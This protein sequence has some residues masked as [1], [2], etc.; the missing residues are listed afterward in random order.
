MLDPSAS[1][2]VAFCRTLNTKIIKISKS[3]EFEAISAIAPYEALYPLVSPHVYY[4]TGGTATL[5]TD[6]GGA[7]N[8]VLKVFKLMQKALLHS[9]YALAGLS[10]CLVSLGACTGEAT[11]L[12]RRDSG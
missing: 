12:L 10:K 6:T 4:F 11:Q 8:V 9:M 1:A 5:E 2:E 3:K 7:Y